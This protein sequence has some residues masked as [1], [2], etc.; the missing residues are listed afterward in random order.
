MLDLIA[1]WAD[2]LI[3]GS[4]IGLSVGVIP[5]LWQGRHQQHVPYA[6]SITFVVLLAVLAVALLSRGLV[7]SAVSDATALGLWAGVAGE[8][9][10]QGR[11]ARKT[12]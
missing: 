3:T 1:P 2:W 12:L 9:W 5:M 4:N 8:R 6:T 10:W 7:F 11:A